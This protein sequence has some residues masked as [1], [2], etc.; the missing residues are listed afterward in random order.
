MGSIRTLT[1]VAL[2]AGL[3]AV[4]TAGLNAPQGEGPK[5]DVPADKKAERQ[6]AKEEKK[7]EKKAAEIGKPAPD[8]TLKDLD[9]KTVKLA[10][11]KGKTVVLEWF[12]PDCP[13]V[14]AA[15]GGGT[16]KDMAANATKD[17]SVVW[18][19][20][21]SGGEGKQGHAVEA[22]KKRVEEWK[23]GNPI[24]RDESGEVGKAYG[25]KTTP[26]MFIVDAKGML[27]YRGA[28]DNAPNGK[29]EGDKVV[30][31]VEAALAELKAGKA[32]TMSS[33]RSYG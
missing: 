9:G 20:I 24:L 14:I 6:E 8:F 16:L 30:N 5:K 22:N 25:A 33:T 4:A 11:Y 7:E 29:P 3:P 31:H 1:L 27:A 18:L 21:N 23:I 32:V 12:N 19:A 13:A 15:H 28:P 26:H 10:D 17:P 2:L